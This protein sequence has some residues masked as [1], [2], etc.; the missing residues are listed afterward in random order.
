MEDDDFKDMENDMGKVQNVEDVENKENVAPDSH[1]I[2]LESILMRA[3]LVLGDQIGS[4]VAKNE[5]FKGEGNGESREK[6]LN[7]DSHYTESL[8]ERKEV[9]DD[10][11]DEMIQEGI[12][13]ATEEDADEDGGGGDSGDP[14]HEEDFMLGS[15]QDHLIGMN[16]QLNGGVEG[17]IVADNLGIADDD[18]GEEGIEEIRGPELVEAYDDDDDDNDQESVRSAEELIVID[19]S[20][21]LSPKQAAGLYY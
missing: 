13:Q 3:K 15:K 7:F 8:R 12:R 9:L 6:E 16:G 11:V 10:I 2:S 4:T 1:Q 21:H 18:Y 19:R 17:F 5:S 14:R 20:I